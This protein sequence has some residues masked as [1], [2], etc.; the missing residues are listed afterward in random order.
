MAGS[1]QKEAHHFIALHENL[2]RGLYASP[3]GFILPN[4]NARFI[5][6]IRSL[7]VTANK[8]ELFAG[9]GFVKD[10][11]AES[12]WLETSQKMQTMAQLFGKNSA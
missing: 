5:V 11:D 7:L 2:E 12:E 6:G 8:I 9:A 10:S 3:L 4:G 1:P